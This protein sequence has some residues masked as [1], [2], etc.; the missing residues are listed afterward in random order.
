M[1][2]IYRDSRGLNPLVRPKVDEVLERFTTDQITHVWGPGTTPDHNNLRCADFMIGSTKAGDQVAQWLID[3]ATRLGVQGII[4]NRRV[5][6]N[7]RAGGQYTRTP[8]H[9]WSPYTGASPHT[10]HVHA[11]FAATRATA[12]APSKPSPDASTADLARAVIAGE[13]GNGDARRKAL[14]DRYAA[15]QAEVNKILSGSKQKPGKSVAQLANETVAGKH[16]NGA[17][18]KRSLGKNYAAVQAEIGRRVDKLAAEVID[19]KHGN[20]DDRRKALGAWYN[21]VQAEVN[22]RLEG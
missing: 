13:F 11:Q 5:W 9:K 8:Q 16:G 10:D 19:G 22:K 2:D 17:A 3:N 6:R 7:A 4:W 18:R 12:P 14:G 20:G 21:P 1:T 15:V